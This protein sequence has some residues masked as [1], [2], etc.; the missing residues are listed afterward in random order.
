M[1]ILCTCCGEPWHT[2]Y[3]LHEDPES[4]ERSG[5]LITACPC[6]NGRRPQDLPKKF[7]DDLDAIR[8]LAIALGDDI[9]G[10]AAILEDFSYTGIV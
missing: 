7:C 10:F 8:E 2:D 3:V 6:C 1:D 4:F 9:D 5:A